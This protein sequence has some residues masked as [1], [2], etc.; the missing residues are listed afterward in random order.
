VEF[1]IGCSLTAQPTKGRGHG[2][3]S[4]PL[5]ILNQRCQGA[6]RFQICRL[7]ARNSFLYHNAS[8]CI[9]DVSQRRWPLVIPKTRSMA[10]WA[11]HERLVGTIYQ[12]CLSRLYGEFLHDFGVKICMCLPSAHGPQTHTCSREAR[13]PDN[14]TAPKP[15]NISAGLQQIGLSFTTTVQK[16]GSRSVQLCLFRNFTRR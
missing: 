2:P 15:P 12:Q 11:S 14:K 9:W 3:R 10:R 4:T 5:A 6:C 1:G 16:A 13:A 8:V 7:K